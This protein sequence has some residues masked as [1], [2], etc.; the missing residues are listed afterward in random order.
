MSERSRRRLSFEQP[1]TS[2]GFFCALCSQSNSN[3]STAKS[4]KDPDS[5]AYV[6]TL[7]LRFSHMSTL[8]RHDISRVLKN[9][10]SLPRWK[11]KKQDEKCCVSNCFEKS[12]TCMR[13]TPITSLEID[14]ENSEIFP[15]CKHHYFLIKNKELNLQTT[16]PTCNISLRNKTT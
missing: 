15:L 8:Y 12:F 16:C 7:D 5:I 2:E 9:P 4:W 13:N 6:T 1:S 14:T 11:K 3:V 10:D